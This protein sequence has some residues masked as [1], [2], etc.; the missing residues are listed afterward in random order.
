MKIDCLAW[1]SLVWCARDLKM[2]GTWQT[3]GPELPIEFARMSDAG[4]GRL[5]LVVTPGAECVTTLW[6]VLD[7][8]SGESA[9]AALR[10]RE[11]CR[12]ADI[13]IWPV[14]DASRRFC[15][16]VIGEWAESQGFDYVIWTALP[17]K[18]G[19]QDGAPPPSSRRQSSTWFPA[20]QR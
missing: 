14:E 1:G 6:S 16:N 11:G 9:R 12:L 3:D 5:T 17:P 8:P 2:A 20:T 10:Q 13:G 19:H 15:A 7:Y 18:F 4:E